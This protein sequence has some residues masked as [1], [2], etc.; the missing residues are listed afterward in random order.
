MTQ[1]VELLLSY[2]KIVILTVFPMFEM[3][4]KRLKF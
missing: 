3:V 2:I 1:M 4:E